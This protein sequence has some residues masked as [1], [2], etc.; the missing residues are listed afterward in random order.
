M[1]LSNPEAL[2]A[3]RMAALEAGNALRTE[4]A[5][6]KR[7][8]EGGKA[9]PVAALKELHESLRGVPTEVYLKWVPGMGETKT[10]MMLRPLLPNGRIRLEQLSPVTRQRLAR[11]VEGHMERV[12][13]N[14]SQRIRKRRVAA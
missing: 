14:R 9:C 11:A 4:R 2:H 5:R 7:E 1:D 6:R 12:F 10:R 3:Q 13:K 8:I